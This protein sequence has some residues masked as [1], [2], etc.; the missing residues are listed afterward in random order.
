MKLSNEH[1]D[2]LKPLAMLVIPLSAFVATLG[3][4]WGIPY[5]LQI[6]QTLVALDALLGAI[7]SYSSH[8]YYKDKNYEVEDNEL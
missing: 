7:L 2:L 6:Q 8:T 3:D 1:Y 5:A 4:I